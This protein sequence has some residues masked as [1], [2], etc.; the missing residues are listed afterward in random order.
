M[1]LSTEPAAAVE[2]YATDGMDSLHSTAAWDHVEQIM[3]ANPTWFE[4]DIPGEGCTT[5]T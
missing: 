1:P 3:G 5:P 2:D 4:S